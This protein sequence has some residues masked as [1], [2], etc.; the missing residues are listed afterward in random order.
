MYRA[1]LPANE[2]RQRPAE[3]LFCGHHWHSCESALVARGASAFDA[4][5]RLVS[6]S[7]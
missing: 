1:V 6:S 5:G 7:C 4:A 2:A 3:L